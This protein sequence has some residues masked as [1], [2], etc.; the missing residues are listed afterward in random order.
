MGVVFAATHR[1]LDRDV[2]LKL[3]APDLSEDGAYRNRFLR[4][5][6]ALAKLDSPYVVRVHD[7]GEQEGWLFIATELVPDGDLNQP[8]ADGGLPLPVAAD[9]VGQV[10]AGLQVAH[11][12]GILHRDIKPSNVLIRRLPDGSLRGVLCDL[13][14]STVQDAEH[15]M[16][17]G[18]IGT[19]RYMAPERHEG[20]DASVA[21]DI[22]SLGCLLWAVVTG[23]APYEGTASQVLLGHLR[24]DVPQLPGTSPAEQSI[25]AVI[26]KAMAKDPTQRF[27]SAADF[28]TALIGLADPGPIAAATVV[29]PPPAAAA[30]PAPELLSQTVVGRSASAPRQV[31]PNRHAPPRNPITVTI[32]DDVRRPWWRRKWAISAIATAMIVA[33]AAALLIFRADPRAPDKPVVAETSFGGKATF[34]FRAVPPAVDARVSYELRFAGEPRIRPAR[35]VQIYADREVGSTVCVVVRSVATYPDRSRHTSGWV[36]SCQKVH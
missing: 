36:T 2:A 21:T 7:A 24:G 11:K 1:D 22:Y 29:A 16:T 4:E 31:V 17:V 25:N 23:R 35:A 19:P 3:L 34:K 15:T 5:A 8:L 20:A 32:V 13:G 6:K 9:L 10:A 28:A 33:A 30:T 26:S 27:A 14:I 12:A 18:V